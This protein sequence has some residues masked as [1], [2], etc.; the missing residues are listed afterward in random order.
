MRI[1]LHILFATVLLEKLCISICLLKGE[2][3]KN[4][5]TC[6]SDKFMFINVV[7]VFDAANGCVCRKHIVTRWQH[8]R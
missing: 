8:P 7:T 4:A 2:N 3:Y 1:S 6:I 5:S